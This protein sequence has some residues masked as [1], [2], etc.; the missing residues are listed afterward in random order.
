MAGEGGLCTAVPA[1]PPPHGL[2]PGSVLSGLNSLN[3]QQP[4]EAG[5]TVIFRQH[6]KETEA[7]RGQGTRPVAL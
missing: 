2:G 4:Y 1:R 7:P 6:E 3:H 5:A